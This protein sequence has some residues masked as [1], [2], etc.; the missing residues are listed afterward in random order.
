[1]VV[2]KDVVGRARD[3]FC[4]SGG[5][6]EE[7]GAGPAA[8]VIPLLQGL[9][10]PQTHLPLLVARRH[11][12]QKQLDDLAARTLSEGEAETQRQ[13]WVRPQDAHVPEGYGWDGGSHTGPSPASLLIQ[14]SSLRLELAKLDKAASHLRQLI[15]VPPSP[16]AP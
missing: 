16:R 4:E 12:L 2:R 5:G 8:D 3:E 15:D 9:V 10:D 7:G 13:Q 14:L 6:A 11:K 1:M